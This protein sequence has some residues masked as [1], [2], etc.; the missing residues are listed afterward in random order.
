MVTSIAVELSASM[1]RATRRDSASASF[2]SRCGAV[3]GDPLLDRRRGLADGQQL[4]GQPLARR[5][6]GR[7]R[8][9]R[10]VADLV[11]LLLDRLGRPPRPPRSRLASTRAATLSGITAAIASR[12]WLA[13]CA[14]GVAHPDQRVDQ[15]GPGFL[16]EL[17]RGAVGLA[18]RRAPAARIFSSASRAPSRTRG[19]QGIERLALA[20]DARLALG[21]AVG[22]E[23]RGGLHR[24]HLA[25]HR[26]APTRRSAR[27]GSR[28]PP[29]PAA[30]R[31]AAAR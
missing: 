8:E 30:F 26:L 31:R 20:G 13:A 11:E 12:A 25:D 17:R 2:S 5:P 29:W 7:Q 3:L 14:G 1:I 16:D 21:D 27:P 15:L 9:V 6:G 24:L 10:G 18:D 19:E 4:P 28:R 22:G 23:R